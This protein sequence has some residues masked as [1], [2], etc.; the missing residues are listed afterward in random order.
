VME[1][2]SSAFTSAGL[3]N[4]NST[5]FYHSGVGGLAF[6]T[7]AAGA[8]LRFATGAVERLRIAA[9]GEVCIN[10]TVAL[11][12]YQILGI[13]ADLS[14]KQPIVCQNTN[15][16]NSGTFQ[17]YQNSAGVACGAIA[18]TAATTIAFQ[19][20]SD[21]RLKTDLGRATD[22]T[23]LRAVVIHD[24]AW[25]ADERH[26]RGVFAQEAAPVFPRAITAG[27]DETTDTGALARPWMTDYSKFVPDL[28]VGWQHHDADLA[29]LRALLVTL[30]GSADAE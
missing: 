1:T 8:S 19:T 3:F 30:K 18:Q 11:N 13:A 23:A 16:S 25:T 12:P 2:Y 14:G 22:L 10:T 20:T 29:E 15:A 5:V 21:Q 27:T 24:F 26:D 4:A 17:Y 7:A 6:V 28:I 9:T